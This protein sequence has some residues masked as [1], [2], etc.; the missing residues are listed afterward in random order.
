[1]G[2]IARPA[3]AD[4]P[5][6]EKYAPFARLDRRQRLG[7]IFRRRSR[8]PFHHLSLPDEP[9]NALPLPSPSPP[10]SSRAEP[11]S[12]LPVSGARRSAPLHSRRLRPA[13]GRK[14]RL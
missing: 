10:L 1:M 5:Q 7:A 11:R 9:P 6:P 3:R 4:R 12:A 14:R 2:G 13:R 8:Y